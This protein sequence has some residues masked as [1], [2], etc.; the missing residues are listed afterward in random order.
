M[1]VQYHLQI[2]SSWE[3]EKNIFKIPYFCTIEFDTFCFEHFDLSLYRCS[4]SISLES[5]NP[6]GC[7]NNPVSWYLRSIWISFHGLPNPSVGFG[8]QS[9]GDFLVGR[10]PALRYRSQKIIGFIG[11]CFH[12]STSS[13]IG[14]F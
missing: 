8:S 14:R 11:K 3:S 5:T 6:T 9:V 13:I 4:R 7:G 2:L 12:F 10:H 1:M